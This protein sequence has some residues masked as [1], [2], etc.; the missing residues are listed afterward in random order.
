M[1][2][3]P[4]W[5]K[6]QLFVA[7]DKLGQMRILPQNMVI[8]PILHS[9]ILHQTV[10]SPR[11]YNSHFP[12]VWGA[13]DSAHTAFF[14]YQVFGEHLLY[15]LCWKWF[16]CLLSADNPKSKHLSIM[17]SIVIIFTTSDEWSNILCPVLI[18]VDRYYLYNT[19]PKLSL[20]LHRV[21]QQ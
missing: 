16:S 19:F 3:K 20:L 9:E 7:S 1:F 21:A 6:C 14:L 15:A 4:R 5:T 18:G 8:Q 17:L 12:G 10:R 2:K 13:W 11:P